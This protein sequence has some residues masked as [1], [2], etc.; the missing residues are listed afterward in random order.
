VQQPPQPQ[1]PNF[2]MTALLPSAGIDQGQATDTD[3][4]LLNIYDR[5]GPVDT[6][7]S[8]IIGE[9]NP[10]DITQFVAV[11]NVL[12]DPNL[13]GTVV[14]MCLKEEIAAAINLHHQVQDSKRA[15]AA[16]AQKK[17]Q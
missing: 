17:E 15:A 9:K 5:L 14:M 11:P 16:A 8:D 2:N 12:L 13:R 3:E 1:M 6:N 10:D 7:L 4:V